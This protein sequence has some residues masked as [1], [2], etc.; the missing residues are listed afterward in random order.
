MVF[1]SNEKRE[2]KSEAVLQPLREARQQWERLA[3]LPGTRV[4]WKWQPKN[5]YEL[6]IN[7][8]RLATVQLGFIGGVKDLSIEVYERRFDYECRRFWRRWQAGG[9][10]ELVEVASGRPAFITTGAHMDRHA[11][12]T[13][14]LPGQG[15]FEFPVQGTCLVDA[16]MSAID[17][18]G[19][20]HLQYRI[21]DYKLAKKTGHRLDSLEVVIAPECQMRMESV[22][23]LIAASSNWLHTYFGSKGGSGA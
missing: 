14:E 20:S 23:L 3:S 1:R 13:I 10:S 17:E 16:V 21:G 9:A 2:R 5:Q 22:L 19:K 6:T 12:G 4:V 8:T 11:G 18:S 7:D 15:T